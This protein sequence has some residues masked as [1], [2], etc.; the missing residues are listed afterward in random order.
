MIYACGYVQSY[1]PL[2]ENTCKSC[3]DM[4]DRLSGYVIWKL[5][6]KIAEN[7]SH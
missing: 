5:K 3:G 7:L 4:T 1:V 6:C 2:V